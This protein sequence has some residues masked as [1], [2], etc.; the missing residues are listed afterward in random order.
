MRESWRP[1]GNLIKECWAPSFIREALN[2]FVPATR[3]R[4]YLG[5]QHCWVGLYVP[6]E[7]EWIEV[8]W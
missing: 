5:W 2:L 7:A 1:L 3:R 8:V 4:F 6:S